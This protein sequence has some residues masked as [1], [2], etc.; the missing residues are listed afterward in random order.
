MREQRLTLVFSFKLII[1]AIVQAIINGQ[2]LPIQGGY[3]QVDTA[4]QLYLGINTSLNTPLPARIDNTTLDL[5]NRKTQPFTPFANITIAGQ[6]L[7]GDTKIIVPPQLVSVLNE[8][9]LISWFDK[10]FS[11][12]K[13]DLSVRGRPSVFLGAIEQT[14][15][16]N[17]DITLPGLRKF[18]GFGID[19]LRI[20]LPPDKNGNNLRGTVNIPNWGVLVL[21]FGNIT[22]NITSGKTQ[23]GQITVY[24]TNLK[25]GNNSLSFDGKLD[26]NAIIQN[27]GPVLQSQTEALNRGQVDLNATGV[28]VVMNGTRITFIETVLSGHPLTASVS[29]ITLLSD[30][31][32]GFVG[33]GSASIVNVLGDVVGNSTFLQH[34]IGHY[35]ATQVAKNQTQSSF[36]KRAPDPKDALMWNML[37]MGLRMKLNQ[38]GR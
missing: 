24:E 3:V 34:V 16:I 22:F 10:V 25:P 1:P 7:K 9:E 26:L 18:A 36:T 27:L 31:I 21:N 13:V 29:V 20:V 2:G 19:D 17:K 11:Q 4:T 33:G 28:A 12:D 37:K 30:V 14:A 35:N 15:N 32:N 38:A 5:F 6:K 8:S 23:I